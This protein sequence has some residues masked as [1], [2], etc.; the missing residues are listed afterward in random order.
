MHQYNILS[1]CT[2]Q[3]HLPYLDPVAQSMIA[4]LKIDIELLP[5]YVEDRDHMAQSTMAVGLVPVA[6]LNVP[7]KIDKV[8]EALGIE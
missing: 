2:Y 7:L 6:Q 4:A 1:A 8:C 5:H 3:E